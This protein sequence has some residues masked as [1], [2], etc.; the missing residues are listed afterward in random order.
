[1]EGPKA[2]ATAGNC[3]RTGGG[4]SARSRSTWSCNRRSPT[5]RLAPGSRSHAPLQSQDESARR[6]GRLLSPD[7]RRRSTPA[8]QRSAAAESTANAGARARSSISITLSGTIELCVRPVRG[9]TTR[10]GG[11]SRPRPTTSVTL[12]KAAYLTLSA[13]VVNTCIARAA[14]AAEVRATEQL[15]VL[16]RTSNSSSPRCRSAPAPRPYCRRVESPSAAEIAANRPARPAEAKDQPD[17]GFA[18]HPG[19][20]RAAPSVSLPDLELGGLVPAGST[21]R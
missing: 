18:G 9:R 13:N 14:Y 2:S 12:A 7:R 16:Q 11:A 4:C 8:R 6:R 21:C 17:R 10:G 3:R 15:I 1:M 19:R 5:I 20:G